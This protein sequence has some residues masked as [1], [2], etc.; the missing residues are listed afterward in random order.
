MAD[1]MTARGADLLR[2]GD[3]WTV[4]TVSAQLA[5]PVGL[6]E[7]AL[8]KV[9][10]RYPL[11]VDPLDESLSPHLLL[12]GCWEPWVS[13]ALARLVRPGDRCLNIGANIGYFAVL[14]ADLCGDASALAC[15]EPCARSASLLRRNLRVN[16]SGAARVVEKMAGSAAQAGRTLY[17]LPRN[18]GCASGDAGF[19]A[20]HGEG[21]VVAQPSEVVRLD[22]ELAG[23]PFDFI[24]I[25]AEGM[26]FEALE[27][28]AG[29]LEPST[30][31]LLEYMGEAFPQ[32]YHR[33]GKCVIE[34]TLEASWWPG[35]PVL[36]HVDHDS[37]LKP[38]SGAEVR[39]DRGRAWTL[40]FVQEG[41]A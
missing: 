16:G 41:E 24:L 37:L 5:N 18:L 23:E 34:R 38:V 15:V 1:G 19:P 4:E 28:C 29:L 6:G 36:G 21:A 8:T 3:R 26:D 25:D 31:V 9:L 14:L 27:G 12:G 39:A 13:M 7:C 2:C 10:G 32:K 20:L 35:K 17:R 30:K 40:A 22:E 33:D 11:Y